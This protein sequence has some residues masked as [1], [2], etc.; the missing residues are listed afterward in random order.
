M[1]ARWLSADTTDEEN[2]LQ[3]ELYYKYLHAQA[4]GFDGDFEAYVTQE[5]AQPVIDSMIPEDEANEEV[6]HPVLSTC[7]EHIITYRI[8]RPAHHTFNII[9]ITM[10]SYSVPADR[11]CQV[12]TRCA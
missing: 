9:T 5:I 10:I 6:P 4:K 11:S 1:E 12:P 2:A 7:R 8:S 3:L